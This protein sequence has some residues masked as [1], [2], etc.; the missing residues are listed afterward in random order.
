MKPTRPRAVAFDVVH[1]LM[2]LEPLRD[3]LTA[4]G[5]PDTTLEWWFDRI[6]RDGM[7]LTST[8]DYVPFRAIA[9]NALRPWPPATSAR[10]PS[11][12][13]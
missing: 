13:S 5:F 1:T 10:P 6:V 9:A 8:G 2:S 12:T 11:S 3:R 4:S 7:A